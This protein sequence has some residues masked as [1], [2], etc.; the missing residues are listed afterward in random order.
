MKKLFLFSML[1][2]IVTVFFLLK[3][4]LFHLYNVLPIRNRL[5]KLWLSRKPILYW[6]SRVRGFHPALLF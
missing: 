1:I 3:Y 5:N 4:N 2:N 6:K